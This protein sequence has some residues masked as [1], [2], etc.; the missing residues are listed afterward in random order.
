M[1]KYVIVEES[2][3]YNDEWY[4]QS[5][6]EGYNIKSKLYSEEDL[7]TAKAEVDRLNEEAKGKDWFRTESWGDNEDVDGDDMGGFIQPFKI[8]K[9]EE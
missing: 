1:A 2:W 5:E 4:F 6:S 7:D 8:V 9:I 3:E